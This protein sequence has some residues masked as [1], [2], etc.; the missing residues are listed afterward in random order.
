MFENLSKKLESF[1][2]VVLIYQKSHVQVH[3]LWSEMNEAADTPA[4][5]HACDLALNLLPRA[6]NAKTRLN[7]I[8]RQESAL[9]RLSS[10]PSFS[11]P[12]LQA[13]P[14]RSSENDLL[15]TQ[16]VPDFAVLA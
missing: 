11:S 7:D 14:S 16:L 10:D 3:N 8:H 13:C 2:Q 15:S 12:L 6:D 9:A 5:S 4:K 1:N